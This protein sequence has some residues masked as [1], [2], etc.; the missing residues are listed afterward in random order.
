MPEEQKVAG[1]ESV[2]EAV[3][4]KVVGTEVVAEESSEAEIKAVLE[5]AIAGGEE[6]TPKETTLKIGLDDKDEIVEVPTDTDE[7]VTEETSTDEGGGEDTNEEEMLKRAGLGDFKTLADLSKS[8]GDQR[9]KYAGQLEPLLWAQ[10]HAPHLLGE[11]YSKIGRAIVGDKG[12]PDV[13]SPLEGRINPN[14]EQPYTAGE[15]QQAE[16]FFSAMAS[17]QGFVKATDMDERDKANRFK[18]DM[19]AAALNTKHM[20]K[21]WK[22]KVEAIGLNW[23][24]DILPG[25]SKFLAGFGVKN[26]TPE[27]IT[28][29]N[30]ANALNSVL[31]QHPDAMSMIVE[32]AKTAGAK[33]SED[34]RGRAKVI[35]TG[36]VKVHEDAGDLLKRM[37]S[38]PL[39]KQGK[40]ILQMIRQAGG[41]KLPV[42]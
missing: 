32:N 38:L 42:L 8:Y 28:P 26:D 29:E 17:K 27:M 35:P 30:L 39:D 18:E 37:E 24:K 41:T 11:F 10:K 4:E 5:K 14:T 7:T 36:S 34:K 9:E 40:L 22:S 31:L 6:E 13:K 33:E 19:K 15:I 20:E 23:D 21:A 3:P 1:Q 12:L 25:M 2:A 16:D